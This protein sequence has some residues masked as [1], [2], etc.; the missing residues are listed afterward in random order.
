VTTA[1]HLAGRGDSSRRGRNLGR[2]AL[3][4]VVL[5]CGLT[6]VLGFANKARCAG[7]EYDAAGRSGPNFNIR[8]DRDVC[9]SDIQ[10]LWL[11][12]DID[13]HVFPYLSGGINQN[14]G[15]YGGTMEY[16]VLTGLMIWAGALFAQTD[17]GFLLGSALLMAPFGLLTAWL[18]GRLSRWRALLWA[19]G[20]PLVL[21]AF[22]NWDL[23]VVACAVG[24]VY[25]VHRGWGATGSRRPLIERATA[26]A[27]LLGLGFA[28]KLYPGAFVLPLALYVLTAS[29]SH[30]QG[31]WSGRYD[32]V[33]ALRVVT[34]AVLTV[35]AVNLPFAV[36]G[37][38]GWWASFA[39]Q[40]HRKVDITTNSIWFWGFRPRS[41]PDNE[42]FQ[43]LMDW[44]SPT[45]V[46]ASFALAVAIGWWRYRRQGAYP[47]VAVSGAMLVGFLLLHKVHSPQYTLWLLPF[48]VLLRVPWS[49]VMGYYLVDAA[50]GIGIF[51]WFYVTKTGLPSGI[52][53][54]WESQAVM[55]GVWGRAI[56]L[57]VLFWV[58]VRAE[59][60]VS[61][62]DGIRGADVASRGDHP[63][64]RGLLGKAAGDQARREGRLARTGDRGA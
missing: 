51:R 44:L 8:Y 28:F 46:F 61:M 50:M 14:G 39:F 24:A 26:G 53:D 41:N 48:L 40:G 31:G 54:S 58:F 33:G 7:P 6:L 38:D 21:Y 10:Y 2:T 1:A 49:L 55:V 64:D 47:W 15:L 37:Y 19:L 27:V 43:S 56:L 4:A 35:V 3:A 9:Y 60:T 62:V 30:G 20:P 16:P 5:L 11:G 17:G 12:R 13:K 36:L 25:V 34:A 57:V 59:A 42:S 23:P 18:L 63:D 52:Y 32:V 45:L 22:H 29:R